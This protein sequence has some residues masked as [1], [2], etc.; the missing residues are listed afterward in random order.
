MTTTTVS[1]DGSGWVVTR[2]HEDILTTEPVSMFLNG[3]SVGQDGLSVTLNDFPIKLGPR[4]VLSIRDGRWSLDTKTGLPPIRSDHL[5]VFINNREFHP[6]SFLEDA[7]F[8]THV[9]EST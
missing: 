7:R 3:L 5:C 1:N 2:S 8:I 9:K 4:M 6:Q